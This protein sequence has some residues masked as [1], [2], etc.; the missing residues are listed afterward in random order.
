MYAILDSFVSDSR[1]M[2]AVPI[3]LYLPDLRDLEFRIKNGVN[4]AP[5]QLLTEFCAAKRYNIYN[6]MDDFL[7]EIKLDR[8]I[9]L[10][11][12]GGHYTARANGILAISFHDY[13]QRDISQ[14]QEI[15]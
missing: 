5:M 8:N 10:F 15:K 2:Q 1:S 9:I 12:P 7:H 3:I 13:I 11:A 14:T 4:P 6:P